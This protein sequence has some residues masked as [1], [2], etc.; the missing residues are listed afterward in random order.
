MHAKGSGAFG[1]FRVTNDITRYTKAKIFERVGKETPLFIRFS[2]VAGERGTADAERDIRG[3]AVKFYTEEGNWDPV[4]NNTQ[5]FFLRDPLKF[6]DLNHV[7]KRDPRTNL[8][9]NAF[10]A[11]PFKNGGFTMTLSRLFQGAMPPERHLLNKV[12]AADLFPVPPCSRNSA[13]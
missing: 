13:S 5:V 8:H 3:F 7:V 10:E 9:S 4:G 2:T 11:P 6:P 12:F 1:T